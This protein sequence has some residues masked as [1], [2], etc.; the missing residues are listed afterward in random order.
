MGA[1]GRKS[2]AELAA[3]VVNLDEIELKPPEELTEDQAEVWRSVVGAMPN[4][5]FS[6]EHQGVLAAYCRHVTR[7]RTV[8]KEIDRFGEDAFD[9]ADA[10]QYNELSKVAERESRAM[11]AC[12]RAL[13]ITHQSQYD[14]SKAGRMKKNAPSSSKLWGGA[15]DL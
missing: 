14:A 8:S 1:R 13:R 9:L 6:D 3:K 15:I 7:H 2:G 12:G 4:D 5:W 11:L 10:K